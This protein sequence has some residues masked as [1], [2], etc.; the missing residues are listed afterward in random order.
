MDLNLYEPNTILQPINSN[1]FAPGVF[2]QIYE[3]D[4]L[5]QTLDSDTRAYVMKHTDEN[6]TR[7]DVENC[8]N[9]L[10]TKS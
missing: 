9:E 3:G 2:T 5:L 7:A 4:K 1:I 8:I 10:Y 6:R